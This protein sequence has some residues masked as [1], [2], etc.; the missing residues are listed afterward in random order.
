MSILK[1]SEFVEFK[2]LQLHDFEQFH[3]MIEKGTIVCPNP[4]TW[5]NF[6]NKFVKK[7]DLD[8]KLLPLILTSWVWTTNEEKNIVFTKQFDA[9]SERY[10]NLG[11][12]PSTWQKII[13]DYFDGLEAEQSKLVVV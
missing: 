8:K 2:Q 7:A 5:L 11:V 10:K 6:Y 1:N 12:R 3:E 13:F 9:I 4:T